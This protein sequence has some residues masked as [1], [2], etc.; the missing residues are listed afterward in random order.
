LEASGSYRNLRTV[1]LAGGVGGAR[2]ALGLAAAVEPENLTVIVNVGDDATM[3]GALVC[4]DLDTVTYTLAGINGARGWGIADDTHIVMDHLATAGIDTTF[5]LGDRDLAHC[6]ARTL[7]LSKGGSLSGFTAAAADRLGIG[8]TILPASDEPIRTKIETAQ[9][10]QLDFQDY[11]V[12]RRHR[13]DVRGLMYLGIEDARP[14]PG[15]VE[16]VAGADLIVIAPSNPPLSIWPILGLTALGD[17]VRSHPQV[18]A[19]SPLI[20]GRAVKGPLVQVMGGLGLPPTNFGILTAYEDLLTHFVIDRSDA[21]DAPGL[22]RLG[23][24]VLVANT[25]ITDPAASTA[26]A[27]ETF[28]HVASHPIAQ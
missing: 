12:L 17:A 23:V 8:C 9:G 5:E 7:H 26:L 3:Y 6:L 20:G 10:E 25:L 19:V 4:A 2:M 11:F 27:I 22:A 24:D 13:D 18:V 1:L 16:A 28:E 14:A 21:A 15:A